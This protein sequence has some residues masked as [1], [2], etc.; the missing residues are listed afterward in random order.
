M[1]TPRT[2]DLRFRGDDV[3][4]AHIDG[5]AQFRKALRRT[6]RKMARVLDKELRA[7]VQPIVDEQKRQYYRHYQRHTG[8]SIRGIRASAAGDKI[9][10]KL[11]SHRYPYLAGQEFGRTSD[12]PRKR[13]FYKRPTAISKG[14]F[15]WKPA[16]DG[17]DDF[18]ERI[19]GHIDTAV[20]ELADRE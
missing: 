11:G 15:W 17:F 12:D 9:A 3:G 4:R 16:R 2:H 13:Q 19:E 14:R 18:V 7:S 1:A 20:T 5:L 8:R 10:L 6:D